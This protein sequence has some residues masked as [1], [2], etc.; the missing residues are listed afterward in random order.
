MFFGLC[1]SP[2]T[3]QVMMNKIFKDMID[4]G[5]VV[6]YM[7]DILIFSEKLTD[8]QERTRQILE[9]LREH[10]LYLKPEKCKFNIQ[11]VEFLGLIVRPNHLSMD[12]TKLTG[13]KDWPTPTN[14][15][16]VRSFL[17]FG[18]FYRRFIGHFAELARPLNN[19]T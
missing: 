10:D 15:K 1:N 14:V 6:I 19:L 3:F 4:E 9:R 2:A 17:G 5:W 18:N 8:H 16:R 12:P 11:E 7:D 13:I